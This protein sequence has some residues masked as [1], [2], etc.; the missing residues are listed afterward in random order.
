MKKALIIS[1]LILF[2]FILATCAQKVEDQIPIVPVNFQEEVDLVKAKQIIET[3]CMECHSA[4]ASMEDR[5]APPLE[6]VKRHYLKEYPVL[7]DF[8][9]AIAT[10]VTDPTE[11]KA[12]LRGAVRRFDLMPKQAISQEDITAVATY[13]Y[14]Y[15]LDK[16]EW[17]EEHYSERHGE[18]GHGMHS[19]GKGGDGHGMHNQGDNDQSDHDKGECGNCKHGEGSDTGKHG[20]E[21]EK[22]KGSCCSKGENGNQNGK[23]FCKK[24]DHSDQSEG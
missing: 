2:F 16:P 17:F 14:Q 3:V 15:E 13:I 5:L 7:E 4:T 11:E 22:G 8:T 20:Q 6:A 18:G 1:Y 21:G 10:F 9:A 23:E 19:K 12:L 24:R